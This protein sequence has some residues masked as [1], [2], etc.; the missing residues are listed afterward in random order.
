MTDLILE[1]IQIFGKEEMF[2]NFLNEIPCNFYYHI[3]G[4]TILHVCEERNFSDSTLLRLLQRPEGMFM[5][6]SVDEEGRTPVQ[7]RGAYKKI[8]RKVASQGASSQTAVLSPQFFLG[9]PRKMK[10][11]IDVN[12]TWVTDVGQGAADHCC[13]REID[14]RDDTLV[15]N[16]SFKKDLHVHDVA[17]RDDTLVLNTSLKDRRVKDVKWWRYSL[18]NRGNRRRLWPLHQTRLHKFLHSSFKT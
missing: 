8:R 15:V 13:I 18:R 9:Y 16:S 4:R 17:W 7:C 12:H 11:S 3:R 14:W 1:C 10:E 2:F 5:F 6:T